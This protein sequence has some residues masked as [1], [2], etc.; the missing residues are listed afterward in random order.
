MRTVE[1]PCQTPRRSKWPNGSQE[2]ANAAIGASHG[3]FNDGSRFGRSLSVETVKRNRGAQLLRCRFFGGTDLRRIRIAARCFDRTHV[4]P[5]CAS[6]RTRQA[7]REPPI[8]R[9][10]PHQPGNQPVATAPRTPLP[11][12]PE[13]RAPA[14]GT[15]RPSPARLRGHRAERR[16]IERPEPRGAARRRRRRRRRARRAWRGRDVARSEH[17]GI[18]SHAMGRPVRLQRSARSSGFGKTPLVP[19]PVPGLPSPVPIR[20]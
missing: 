10:P 11:P 18:L 9:P 15:P 12:Y 4:P 14:G 8:R 13:L 5:G 6:N 3:S 20:P 1:R 7:A 19:S 2:T 17:D 16:A